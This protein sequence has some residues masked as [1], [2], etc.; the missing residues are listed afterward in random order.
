MLRHA[1]RQRG[2]RRRYPPPSRGAR[3]LRWCARAALGAA[4]PP[5]YAAAARSRSPLQQRGRPVA[6]CAPR[7][8][9]RQ[10]R[11]AARADAARPGERR[12]GL[13]DPVHPVSTVRSGSMDPVPG[14]RGGGA[15]GGGRRGQR[16]RCLRRA[17]VAWR[18]Y[19]TCAT[20]AACTA[21]HEPG[22][23]LMG[24]ARTARAAR[25]A[26]TSRAARAA[27]HEVAHHG[28]PRRLARLQLRPHV[29]ALLPL[30]PRRSRCITALCVDRGDRL[31]D[32]WHWRRPLVH[33]IKLLVPLAETEPR[34]RARRGESSRGLV[35]VA[36]PD[37]RQRQKVGR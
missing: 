4:P 6:A 18:G 21:D 28:H 15:R 37:P 26:R 24:T 5:V 29:I 36:Q 9:C 13:M 23:C 3:M 33:R 19:T 30:L 32:Q 11:H 27:A 14:P 22:Q 16:Q 20:R 2:R 25:T 12:S 17:W 31:H 8:D 10:G 34:S 35:G 1:A 7:A